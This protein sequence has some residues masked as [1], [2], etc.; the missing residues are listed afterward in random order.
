[1][2]GGGALLW[3]ARQNALARKALT[4]KMSEVVA[5]AQAILTW[6]TVQDA[7]PDTTPPMGLTPID[8]VHHELTTL[9]TQISAARRAATP[10]DENVARTVLTNLDRATRDLVRTTDTDTLSAFRVTVARAHGWL[11]AD[12]WH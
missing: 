9:L 5:H 2:I 11:D 4:G 10:D 12:S 1:V 6:L 3:R 8:D 7:G